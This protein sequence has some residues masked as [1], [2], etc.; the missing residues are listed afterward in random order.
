MC[1]GKIKFNNM[2]G[3]VE[4]INYELTD[5]G[6]YLINI[7]FV[8]TDSSVSIETIDIDVCE[9]MFN[10]ICNRLVTDG[11]CN[12]DRFNLDGDYIDVLLS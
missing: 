3:C 6:T 1:L 2:F 4:F 12:V 5:V 11:Y 7:W 10:T 8:G 9:K